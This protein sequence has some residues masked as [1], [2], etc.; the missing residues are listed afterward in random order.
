VIAYYALSIIKPQVLTYNEANLKKVYNFNEATGPRKIVSFYNYFR[1]Y[2]PH[3]KDFLFGSGPGT[4]NSRS[5]F[6]IGSPYFFT[7]VS[8]IKSDKKPPYFKNYA[9]PLWNDTNTS[10]ALFQ[11]GFRNQPFSS[12]L[13][14]LGEYGLVFTFFFL[15]Y[16]LR[17]YKKVAGVAPPANAPP[18]YYLYTRLFKFLLIMLM[19]LLVI[20]NYLEYAEIILLITVILKLLHAEIIKLQTPS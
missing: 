10:M 5:A 19:L 18:K 7:T 2:P 1:A 8:A 14:F 17:Y 15:L 20:D 6:M 13:A 9:Y 11:D 16:V 12:L 3:I 4:F